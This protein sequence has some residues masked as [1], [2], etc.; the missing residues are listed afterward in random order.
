MLR[1]VFVLGFITA[2]VTTAHIE[3]NHLEDSS[4]NLI[5][6]ALGLIEEFKNSDSRYE[7]R[8]GV[9]ARSYYGGTSPAFYP[10]FDPISILASLAFLAFL[11]QSFAALFDRSRSIIP[12][13]ISSRD[14]SIEDEPPDPIELILRALDEFEAS[15]NDI[16]TDD[17]KTV[18]KKKK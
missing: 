12:A 9:Q 10:A 6:G 14:S 15:N 11:L 18:T 17:E 4:R 8:S 3:S 7:S 2:T 13:V 5:A 16:N 1:K